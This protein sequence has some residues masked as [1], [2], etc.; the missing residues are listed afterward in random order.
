MAGRKIGLEDIC[1]SSKFIFLDSSIILG[2][3][4]C[5]CDSNRRKIDCAKESIEYFTKKM[6]II[7]NLLMTENIYSELSNFSFL[8]KYPK[9]DYA[10]DENNC[11]YIEVEF[12]KE[13]QKLLEKVAIQGNILKLSKREKKIYEKLNSRYYLRKKRHHLS[14]P[15][16]NLAISAM[17][18]ANNEEKVSI[19]SNDNGIKKMWYDLVDFEYFGK[20]INFFNHIKLGKFEQIKQHG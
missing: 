12:Q 13:K 11:A 19:I 18:C 6:D 1:V 7:N 14:N 17:T 2:T 16:Y 4:E 9:C 15:D 5:L 3:Y 10:R 8:S 20:N